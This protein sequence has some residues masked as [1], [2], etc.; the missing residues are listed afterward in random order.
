MSFLTRESLLRWASEK[1]RRVIL[2]HLL[3]AVMQALE[4]LSWPDSDPEFGLS[5]FLL[6]YKE[7]FW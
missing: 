7:A 3:D 1:G 6:D 2:P 4:L 5:A